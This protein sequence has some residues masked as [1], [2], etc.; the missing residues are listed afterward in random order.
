MTDEEYI[1]HLYQTMFGRPPYPEGFAVHLA[2]MGS[3]RPRDVLN[4]IVSS[5]EYLALKAPKNRIQRLIRLPQG[6]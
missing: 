3:Q 4:S 1:S 2:I 6:Q 5:E